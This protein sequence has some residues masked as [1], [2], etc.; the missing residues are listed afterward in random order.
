[1]KGYEVGKKQG[2]KIINSPT[3]ALSLGKCFTPTKVGMIVEG[4]P[5]VEEWTSVGEAIHQITGSVQWLIGDWLVFGEKKYGETYLPAIEA[6]GMDYGSLRNIKSVAENVQLSLRNDNL[7]FN[8][9]VAVSALPPEQ[10]REWLER[11]DQD[12]LSVSDLRKAIRETRLIETRNALPLP[13]DKY[14]VILADPPWKYRDE[15]IEGYGAAEHHYPTLA[16]EE[17]MELADES[18]KTIS[19]LAMSDAVLFLWATSP[20]IDDALRIMDAWGF[21]YK[22]SFVWD[23]VKHNYGHYNSVRHEFLLIGTRGSCT[24]DSK[25]LHDSVVV[26]ERSDKHSE[27]PEVFYELIEEMY[28]E[29]PRLELFARSEREGWKPWGNQAPATTSSTEVK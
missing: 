7:S 23:K 3:T 21:E 28:T 25:K 4:E 19:Q 9:H 29:G 27:K 11:A 10:Q 5:T 20:L 24:P 26:C 13:S 15:L 6:T 1:M 16:V 22:S 12:D 17:L 14:R 8:H 18:G 2:S